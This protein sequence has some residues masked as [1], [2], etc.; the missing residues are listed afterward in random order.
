MSPPADLDGLSAAAL[1]ALVVQLL[2]EVRALKQVVAD[3]RAEIAR[4]KGLKGPPSINPSLKPSGMEQASE[5]KSPTGG[6]KRR[7]RGGKQMRRVAIED[8]VLTAEVP[9]GSRFKGYQSF[10]IQDLVLRPVAIRYRR[11]RWVTPDGRTVV[12]PLPSGID[13]HFGPELRRF[14]LAQYHQGQVT[15]PRLVALLE[16]IGIAV[17]KRQVVRLLIGR[18]GRFLDEARDVL[19]A[20]AGDGGL[21]HGRRHRRPP[22]GHKRLLYPDRQRPL[23]LVRHG[24]IEKPAQFPGVVARRPWRLRDQRRGARL[25]A[26]PIACRIGHLAAG[27]A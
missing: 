12:A 6:S 24:R 11:E 22:Q 17:S 25:Y 14:V 26:R 18:Q 7:G 13:G 4:L 21:D 27:R 16:A 3:Q 8:Q 15:V 20:G 1:K 2:D 23:R 9:A 19:R 5:R 10:L